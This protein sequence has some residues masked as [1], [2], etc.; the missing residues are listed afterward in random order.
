MEMVHNQ[1]LHR[2]LIVTA[3]ELKST[4][5]EAIF[6]CALIAIQKASEITTTCL[7]FASAT[8]SAFWKRQIPQIISMKMGAEQLGIGDQAHALIT[9][10]SKMK[11]A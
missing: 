9:A 11:M 6:A 2:L 1:I 10:V 8:H 5:A 7:K 4:Q 3:A